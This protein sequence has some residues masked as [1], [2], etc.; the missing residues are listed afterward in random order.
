MYCN[1]FISGG[2]GYLGRAVTADLL[3][4]GHRVSILA[5]AGS[6]KK[7][8]AGAVAIPGDALNAATFAGRLAG[9]DTLIH[10]TGTPHPAP[11]KEKQFRAV[12]QVS[13]Q[14][15]V[16][17]ATGA[18]IRHF[19]YVSVAHPAPAMRAYIQ[20][21][22]ECEAL[23]E[24]SGLRRTILRPWYVLGP[25]HQWPRLLRPAYAW[26]ERSERFRDGALRLGLVTLAQM[27]AALVWAVENPPA[28]VQVLDVPAIRSRAS[29]G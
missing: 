27:S 24:K 9:I 28:D 15:S 4:R 16:A 12:D 5:R 14:A 18:S 20:V 1:V 19:V 17:A 13:L 23:L 10:L 3:A 6:E 8:L 22:M 21:R 29:S 2:T 7:V 25:G 11:W 26:A